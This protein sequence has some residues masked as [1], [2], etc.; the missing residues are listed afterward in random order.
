MCGKYF[1]NTTAFDQQRHIYMPRFTVN[2]FYQYN[3]LVSG[4]NIR[5]SIS[6]TVYSLR[7]EETFKIPVK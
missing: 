6:L 5:V 7:S 2:T 4:P 1:T 3:Y